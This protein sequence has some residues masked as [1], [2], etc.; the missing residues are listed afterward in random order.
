MHGVRFSFPGKERHPVHQERGL[1]WRVGERERWD[2]G[3]RVW[4]AGLRHSGMN[5]EEGGREFHAHDRKD[6]MRTN[7]QRNGNSTTTTQLQVEVKQHKW[8]APPKRAVYR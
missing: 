1:R 7:N 6:L 3:Y 8:G 4:Q 2:G 5:K